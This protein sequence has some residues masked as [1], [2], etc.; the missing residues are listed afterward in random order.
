MEEGLLQ[1][2]SDLGLP[3]EQDGDE[4]NDYGASQYVNT[5]LD[6]CYGADEVF[7]RTF[8]LQ[9]GALFAYYTRWAR[10]NAMSRCEHV[11]TRD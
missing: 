7:F 5:L 4:A 2:E 3:E 6:T 1:N 9:C 10:I 11:V 8:P